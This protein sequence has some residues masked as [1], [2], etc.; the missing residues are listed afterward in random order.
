MKPDEATGDQSA[1]VTAVST[2]YGIRTMLLLLE[3]RALLLLGDDV[4]ADLIPVAESLKN[5]AEDDGGYRGRGQQQPRA[6]STAAVLNALHRIA[7]AEDFSAH[8]AQMETDLG[9]FEKSRPFILTT[10]LE[11]S[12]CSDAGQ[13]SSRPSSKAS[14]RPA[15]RTAIACCG[16]RRVSPGFSAPPRLWLIP[17]ERCG[18]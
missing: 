2:A 5:M 13:G 8:V 9:D 12:L 15:G 3:V 11:T 10:M 14:W 6:E 1:G 7:P 17:R 16:R 18:H 4:A